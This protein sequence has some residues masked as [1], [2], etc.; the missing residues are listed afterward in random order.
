MENIEAIFYQAD[1]SMRPGS[2]M[3]FYP[4]GEAF[5]RIQLHAYFRELHERVEYQVSDGI[6]KGYGTLIFDGWDDCTGASVVKVSLRTDNGTDKTRKILFLDSAFTG[7][8]RMSSTTYVRSI[9]QVIAK[10]CRPEKFCAVTSDSASAFVNAKIEIMNAYRF[11]TRL[12]LRT[13]S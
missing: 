9:E 4:T 10:F 7:I 1:R 6:C 3:R 13:Y 12:M 5:T 2:A 8:S 11:P